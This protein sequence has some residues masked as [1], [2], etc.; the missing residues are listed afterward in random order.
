MSRIV[1]ASKWASDPPFSNRRLVGSGFTLLELLLSLVVFAAIA[2]IALPGASVLLAD[3]RIVRGGDQLRTEMV[4]ARVDAM[5]SGRVMM[6]EAAIDGNS[7]RIR[8]FFSATD[9]VE[10]S[11]G[12]P[13]TSAL[14]NGAEQAVTQTI[15][16]DDSKTRQFQIHDTLKVTSVQVV[17]AARAMEISQTANFFAPAASNQSSELQ[18]AS[19]QLGQSWS[20]PIMFYPDGT[21]STAAVTIADDLLGS[22]TV[23]LRG[24]TGDVSVTEVNP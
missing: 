21:T 16:I 3:R 5:R 19:Q 22:V 10:S 20:Q 6:I 9:A 2:S 23:K 24:V 1:V 7:F 17:S 11:D 14:L 12:P 4:R 13:L 8:P 18:P 15:V